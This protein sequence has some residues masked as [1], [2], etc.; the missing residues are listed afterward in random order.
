MSLSYVSWNCNT[1]ILVWRG[2]WVA[3]TYRCDGRLRYCHVL[4]QFFTNCIGSFHLKKTT[5][6]YIFTWEGSQ[7]WD[8]NFKCRV[9]S[10]YGFWCWE[11]RET[12]KLSDST[13]LLPTGKEG[14]ILPSPPL[15]SDQIIDG[16][17]L[18][19]CSWPHLLGTFLGRKAEGAGLVEPS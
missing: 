17:C 8:L 13:A 12:L 9:L 4:L 19:L 7:V 14:S 1:S 6:E 15:I 18:L 16:K 2:F 10:S 11:E 5:Q 3:F